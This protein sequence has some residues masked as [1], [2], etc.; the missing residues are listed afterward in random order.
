MFI[1]LP[2]LLSAY[3]VAT[4]VVAV[5]GLLACFINGPSGNNFAMA[6]IVAAIWPIVLF[7]LIPVYFVASVFTG[8]MT[9]SI[10]WQA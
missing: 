10:N 3:Y 2:T 4:G 9:L 8:G 6:I 1:S 7:L 5:L